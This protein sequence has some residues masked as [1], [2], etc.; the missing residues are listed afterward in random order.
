MWREMLH[1][2]HWIDIASSEFDGM[3]RFFRTW[4]REED[5]AKREEDKRCFEYFRK[6]Q[7]NAENFNVNDCVM[8]CVY[9]A[10]AIKV[11]CISGDLEYEVLS[12][13]DIF[14]RL[15]IRDLE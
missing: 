11:S 10:E 15:Y 3:V 7:H 1:R 6:V 2:A 13:T 14:M 9:E 12:T 4:S 8:T 5:E